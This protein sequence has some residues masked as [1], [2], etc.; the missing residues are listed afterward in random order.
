MRI[1][2]KY[3]N[4]K[5]QEAFD[6]GV[7]AGLSDAQIIK[8]HIEEMQNNNFIELRRQNEIMAEA[9]GFSN[10]VFDHAITLGYLG[11]G[12]TLGMANDAVNRNNKAL[13]KCGKIT[14]KD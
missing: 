8:K 10:L 4:K 14:N 11:E 1:Q 5:E 6:C 2:K 7:K 3:A 13:A 12:S 9:L